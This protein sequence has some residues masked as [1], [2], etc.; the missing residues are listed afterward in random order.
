MLHKRQNSF[1]RFAV[2]LTACALVVLFFSAADV[3]ASR[4]HLLIIN[5]YHESAPWSQE[6]ILPISLK[7]AQTESVQA[8]IIHMNNTLVR[9]I[10]QYNQLENVIFER[11][12]HQ[13][14]DYVVMLGGM[15][16]TLR[17]RILQ[18]WGDI[19]ILLI[20]K[21]DQYGPT[22]Y[23]F[24]G[25]TKLAENELRPMSELLG[26]YNFT[27]IE[28]PDF[29]RET[30]NMMVHMLP[31]M[32]KLVYM[33]DET[34]HSVHIDNL[35][36]TYVTEKYPNLEYEWS[37]GNKENGE[38]MQNFLVNQDSTVGL[39]MSTWFYEQV[40]PYGNSQLMSGDVRLIPTAPQ[41]VFALRSAYLR[42][43]ITG[44]YFPDEEQ[45]RQ[46]IGDALVQMLQGR[47][48]RDLPF[49]YATESSP[50]VNY[51]QLVQDNIDIAN[52][53]KD[54]VFLNR[55]PTFL[56]QYILPVSIIL[57]VLIALFVIVVLYIVFQRKRIAL[58]GQYDAIVNNMPICYT[59]ATVC[60][61][62]KHQVTDIAYHSGNESFD[63]LIGA[64]AI[65]DKPD[66]LL[67]AEYIANLTEILLQ[68]KQPVSF[69]YYFKQTDT[70]YEFLLCLARRK[71]FRK[72]NGED[73][74]V[75]AVN[76]TELR[77]SEKELRKFTQKLDLTLNLA[78]I[79]PWRWDL[80]KKEITCE[81]QRILKNLHV[82]AQRQVSTD[83]T[84]VIRD[85]EY[86][87]R[88]HEEDIPRIKAI[89]Y[90]LISAKKQYAKAEFR[91]RSMQYGEPHV[92]WVEVNAV[93]SEY[94]DQQRPVALS[95][96][97]L[98]ITERKKQELALVAAREK[99]AESD[100]LKSAFLANMSHEIRTP[101]NAIVGFSKLLSNTDNS[102]KKSKFVD[103]IENNNQLL[104]QLINDV[105]DLAKIE[106]N[107]LEF[108]YQPA[109]LNSL[110]ETVENTVR[111][112]VKPGVALNR[113]AGV[114]NCVIQTEPNRLSQVLINLLTNA[115]KFTEQGSIDFGYVLN[116]E[117]L[118]FFVKDSGIGISAETQKKL[119][120]RFSK[121]NN[122]AQ[123]TGLGL[124]ISKTIIEKMGG[125]IGVESEG[126]GKGSTFWFTLPY[127]PVEQSA[128]PVL[129]ETPKASISKGEITVL[130]AEDNESNYLLFQ[131]ILEPE[132]RLIHAWDGVEAVELYKQHKPQ[133]ILMDINM[134]NMDGYEA[135]GEIRKIS[136]TVP[137]I[138]VTAY[139]FIS[140]KKKI[141]DTGFNS[142]VSK[143]LNADKLMQELK[144]VLG[145]SFIML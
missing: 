99:A 12:K 128:A 17:D 122:F 53:P 81:A 28:V 121:Q 86:F 141:M 70:Y 38:R 143:P 51:P 120:Q 20:D 11:F 14:P 130:V 43:G 80:Q 144:S 71:H 75:F 3:Y 55:P 62:Q 93:A 5:S 124:S 7:I 27:L 132:Y 39:L 139:A 103:I 63:K 44:G 108:Y 95:G 31:H 45:T 66:K 117:E 125:R 68:K 105:L 102:E 90:D 22:D 65:P 52:C 101:L 6:L 131:A 100:R 79:V 96:S 29:Y 34:Y 48:M 18:E 129:E 21:T 92:D 37:V 85:S 30:V 41:P 57:L 77:K 60:F 107:T 46:S 137:I 73:I 16:F 33:A 54:T 87:E 133:V 83:A 84:Y 94:D 89:Y 69:T 4:K 135:A 76:V 40:D 97:L 136:P 8:S 74:D 59:Q 19:P 140:D 25:Q 106:A 104:L 138:A 115:C 64:N 42:F 116:K 47:S 58:L 36:R 50:V 111:L 49:A 123:G 127:L 88:I 1:L 109:D 72:Q 26:K 126:E 35:L 134:P 67:P 145:K 9:D 113:L 10:T 98:V 119:F 114:P 24:T 2:R 82:S 15:A 32:K 13:K 142:Y 23:Y 112:R 56:E 118:Y 91:V 110:T 61:N 78:R